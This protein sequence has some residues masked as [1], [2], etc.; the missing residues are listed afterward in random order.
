MSLN[1]DVYMERAA[2]SI[3]FALD[4]PTASSALSLVEK[5]RD[6]VGVF[7]VGLQLFT[8]EG[9]DLVRMIQSEGGRVFLDLKLH[10]IPAT[11]ERAGTAAREL[12]V[13]MFT[14]HSGDGPGIVGAA[15]KGAA[16]EK[17]EQVGVA[18]RPLVLG[19]TVLTSI[20]E[21]DLPALGF[22]EDVRSLASRRASLAVEA[23]CPGLVCSPDE[24]SSLRSLLG[25]DVVLV[26]PGVRPAWACVEGDDQARK[27]SPGRVVEQGGDYVVVG[28]PI[29]DHDD[30]SEAAR[31][32]RE[33]L[34]ETFEKMDMQGID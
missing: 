3:I 16:G 32:I 28:R 12:G 33:E 2:R 5:T 9:P 4:V 27:A 14:V 6:H 30:P 34:A 29:R 13:F 7:K 15:V 23:G 1:S 8:K 20:S 19:V 21:K 26:V 18:D 10:D 11:V 22:N 31:R 25:K 17:K 24:V